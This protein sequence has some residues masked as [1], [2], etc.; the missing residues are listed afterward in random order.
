MSLRTAAI[1]QALG[2]QLRGDPERVI[3]RLASLESARPEDLSFLA[4]ARLGHL[5]ASTQ[6]GCLVVG[7]KL[8]DAA[9][10]RG[11]CIVAADP[12]LYFAQ[13]T[14]LWK[15]RHGGAARPGIHPSAVVEEGALVDPSASIG[16]LS[17]IGRG[18]RIGAHTVIRERVTV[19]EGCAIGARCLI[20]SGAVIGGDGFGFAPHQGPWVKIEQLGAVRIGDDVE[21]GANTCIDRGALDDTVIEDGAKLDNLIQLGHNGHV[22]RHTIMAGCVGVAGSVRIGA[23]CMVGGAVM[24]SGHLSIADKVT[25]SGGSLVASSI[26]EPGHYTGI[27]PI[28]SDAEWKKNA[29]VLRRLGALRER[30]RQLERRLGE[31]GQD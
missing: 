13:L 27:Y 19:A 24:I 30:V 5:L 11:D 20:E 31:P 3:A 28:A 7:P 26:K 2:G 6:A 8:A 22:G 15:R 4:D 16:A 10:A 9:A 12:H 17:F 29:A 14:Q 23:H 18:A 21:I 25:I 1:V